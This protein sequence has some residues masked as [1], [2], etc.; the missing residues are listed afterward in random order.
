MSKFG[1]EEQMESALRYGTYFLLHIS[2]VIESSASFAPFF[3]VCIF[4]E[5]DLPA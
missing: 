4:L 1:K 5:A 2:A 3:F